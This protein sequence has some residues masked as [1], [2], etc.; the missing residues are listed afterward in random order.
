M[1]SGTVMGSPPAPPYTDMFEGLHE[2]GLL[3]VNKPQLET[4]YVRYI[5]KN[6]GL[7]APASSDGP[8]A[9]NAT[10]APFK[11]YKNNNHRLTW[12]FSDRS[13]KVNFMDMTT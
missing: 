3:A 4:L 2:K 9:D 8:T 7:W 1:L 11:A 6:I 10:W 13:D 12:I 5:D